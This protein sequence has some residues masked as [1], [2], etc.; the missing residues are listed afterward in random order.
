MTRTLTLS[1]GAGDCWGSSTG[2]FDNTAT[3]IWLLDSSG[4]KTRTWLPFTVLLP[5]NQIII[6]ATLKLIASITSG[7]SS[8][9]VDFGCEAADN[10][11]NPVDQTD[12]FARTI[13]TAKYSNSIA[14]YVIGTTYSYD[15]T[16]SVQEI[17]NRSGWVSGNNLAILTEWSGF[18]PHAKRFVSNEGGANK[19][20]LEI[21]VYNF[22]PKA[23][24]II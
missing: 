2:A 16:N 8:D 17:I 15:V 6:T 7:T 13:S 1:A 12:L 4:V 24:A 3:D 22:V 11:S 20:V 18:G 19:P 10:P 9:T 21:V 14:Q 23:Q 5:R